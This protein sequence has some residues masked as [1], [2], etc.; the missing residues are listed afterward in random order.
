VIEFCTHTVFEPLPEIEKPLR[1]TN[2]DEVTT[3]WFSDYVNNL[4][5]ELLFELIL[6][7]NFL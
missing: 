2:F 5:T 1:T 3:P 4:D 6:A 7:A